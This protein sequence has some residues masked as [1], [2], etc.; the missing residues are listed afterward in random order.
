MSACEHG[1]TCF[2]ELESKEVDSILLCLPVH[3][4][5]H[6]LLIFPGTRTPVCMSCPQSWRPEFCFP[7]KHFA[8]CV[9]VHM[10]E[11]ERIHGCPVSPSNLWHHGHAALCPYP[12]QGP[13]ATP[14]M[15]LTAPPPPTK[16]IT[17]QRKILQSLN[18]IWGSNENHLLAG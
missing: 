17:F 16:A 4:P 6:L 12:E 5:C 8:V 14:P 1:W 7:R 2:S 18:G 9:C 10:C 3:S 15:T 11:R 13:P